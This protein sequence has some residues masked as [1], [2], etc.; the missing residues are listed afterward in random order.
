MKNISN[1]IA[2]VDRPA[3]SGLGVVECRSVNV[4]WA[5]VGPHDSVLMF[6]GS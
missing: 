1:A 5:F 4:G 2:A 6:V 3:N